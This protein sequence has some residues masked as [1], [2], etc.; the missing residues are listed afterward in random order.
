MQG[1][2]KGTGHQT[3]EDRDAFMLKESRDRIAS[4]E[5][6]KKA[7]EELHAQELIAKDDKERISRAAMKGRT[8]LSKLKSGIAKEL[9]VA[10]DEEAL[11]EFLSKHP[12]IRRELL[13]ES[14]NL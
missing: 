8:E 4:L 7:T 2:N 3:H 6:D 1:H 12:R 11:E 14:A 5:K 13:E 9:R 10:K